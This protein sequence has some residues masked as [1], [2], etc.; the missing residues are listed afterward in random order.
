MSTEADSTN[1]PPGDDEAGQSRKSMLVAA[2]GTVVEWYDFTLYLYLAPV[3]TRVFFGG[4]EESLLYTFG[5]FAAAYGMRPIGAMVFGN[6][7]DKIGRKNSLVVSAVLMAVA[8]FLTAMIPSR[9]SIGLTAPILLFAL[10][11]VMGFSVGGEYTGILVYLLESARRQRRGYATSWA[12]ANSEIGTLL[13]VGISTLLIAILSQ[14][15][16]DAWGWRVTFVVGGFLALTMLFLRRH[17]DETSSF[18]RLKEQGETSKSPLKDVIRHQPRAVRAAFVIGS[19]SSV[20]YYLNVTYVPTFLTE[21][22]KIAGASSLIVA[23]VAAL[24]VLIVTPPIG[25][26]SDRTGRRPLL[27]GF[28]LALIVSTP[29]LFAL[30]SVQSTVA[31]FAGV[32]LIAIPAAAI[33]SVSASAMP[34]QFAA[35]GRFSGL[36]IGFNVS[37]SIFGGFTPLIAT[38]LI[39]LTGWKPA[40]GVYLAVVCLVLLPLVRKTRETAGEPLYDT[41][42][43]MREAGIDPGGKGGD[44]SAGEPYPKEGED[45]RT[46][47]AAARD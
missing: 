27:I 15:Q 14:S 25:I 46:Q 44:A 13:S 42:A 45:E 35:P 31:A 11:C 2:F 8:M 30:M 9:D 40:P 29:L 3:L 6:L 1:A 5:V 39:Q 33:T 37:T 19:V 17:L 7:G 36:A 18:E 24:V 22:V 34:E 4:S 21:E 23:T 16:M 28:T 32:V 10:R 41:V 38:G 12:A 26:W 43:E 20:A 47:S